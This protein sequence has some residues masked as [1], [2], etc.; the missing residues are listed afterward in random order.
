VLLG[1]AR[2][3]QPGAVPPDQYVSGEILI[4]FNPSTSNNQRDGILASRGASRIRRFTALDIDQVRIPPG[5]NVASVVG[6]IRSA[7]EVLYAEPN[8]LRFAVASA[9]SNDPFWLNDTLWGM[10]RVQAQQAWG[11]STGNPSV[12]IAN[13]DTGINYNHQDLAG[14][15]WRNPLEIPANNIDDDGNGYIDDVYGIDTYNHD[16]D[17]MDDRG[18]GTH[19]SGTLAAVGNNEIGVVGINWNAKVLSCKFLNASGSGTDSGAIEC[20]NYIVALKNRGENIRVTNNS[21]GSNYGSALLQ[22][23]IE[24]AGNAGIINVCAAGNLGS[25]NDSSPFYPAGF[26]SSTILAVAASDQSDNPASFS[27]YG[28]TS[29]DIAAP[30]VSIMSTY[31]SS[32]DFMDGTSMATPHVAGSAALL[33]SINPALS[34]ATIKSLLMNNVDHFPQWSSMVVSAAASTCFAP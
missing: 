3:Q 10:Q 2:A 1:S 34:V 22:S 12:V 14:N 20:L 23:A 15:V 4:K 7:P 24:A 31:G 8:Y 13:I 26:P 16:S 27:S 18:H 6:A 30:G 19:T 32:Y 25:N 29:V 21:W 11:V 17:P 28:P 5:L 33:A 9:P